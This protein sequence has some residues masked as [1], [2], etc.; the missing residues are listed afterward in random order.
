MTAAVAPEPRAPMVA[1]ASRLEALTGLRALA[2][3]A[4]LMY[5]FHLTVFQA[6]D[7]ERFVPFIGHCYLGVDLF[8]LL[9]GF[10]LAHVHGQDFARP[11]MR[12]AC[13]FYALRLARIYPV[14]AT[15][16]LVF[17][18]LV[19]LQG[20]LGPSLGIAISWPERY[21][22]T[23]FFWHL[24]LLEPFRLRWNFP[25]WSVSAE[26]FAYLCFPLLAW[27]LARASRKECAAGLAVVLA[28]FAG[29]YALAYD[30]SLDQNGLG[31]VAFEFVA[32]FLL[33]R[34]CRDMRPKVLLPA[35]AAVMLLGLLSAATS[36]GDFGGVLA[37]GA[38]LA[39]AGSDATPL[40]PLLAPPLMLWLGEISY[41]VYMAQ[42]FVMGTAG[43]L[44]VRLMP[45]LPRLLQFATVPLLVALAV[46]CGAL[47][48]GW[49]EKPARDRL[50]R[51]IERRRRRGPAATAIAVPSRST[52]G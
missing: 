26:W 17:L 13:R 3:L 22:P 43:R 38:L 9:S 4:V 35:A 18:V 23:S 24:A 25:A 19:S 29:V 6:L 41:S 12:G 42:A 34:V 51:L 50:R 47:L 39:V 11:R 31:R 14:H 10:I 5:H 30:H 49:V 52:A 37:L 46:A 1:G 32:G 15:M 21:T 36:W 28:G 44:L 40:E 33:Y 2:A 45:H 7:L 16:M 27:R 20:W 8:F 48:H